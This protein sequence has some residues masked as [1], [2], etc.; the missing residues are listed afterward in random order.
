MN[1]KANTI[2]WLFDKC[3]PLFNAQGNHGFT[4]SFPPTGEQVLLQ[5]YGYHRY[6]QDISKLKSSVSDAVQ[7]VITDL[8]EW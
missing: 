3:P 5:F 7:L 4:C 1:T 2:L 8:Q 6:L